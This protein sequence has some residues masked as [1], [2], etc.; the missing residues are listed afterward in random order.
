MGV[1]LGL[2]LTPWACRRNRLTRLTRNLGILLN[3]RFSERTFGEFNV[4][5]VCTVLDVIAGMLRDRER[6]ASR[7]N[8]NCIQKLGHAAHD[9]PRHH[10]P[11]NLCSLFL[12]LKDTSRHFA[13]QACCACSRFAFWLASSKHHSCPTCRTDSSFRGLSIDI[14]SEEWLARHGSHNW[15]AGSPLHHAMVPQGT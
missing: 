7:V 14:V 10:P 5:V 9:S 3:A 13:P 4:V 2:P 11:P 8:S 15:N 12:R 6:D 1:C